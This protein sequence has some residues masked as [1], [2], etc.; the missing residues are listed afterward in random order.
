[1][2]GSVLSYNEKLSLGMYHEYYPGILGFSGIKISLPFVSSFYLGYAIQV[3]V[4]K[5]F[6]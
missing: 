1:M 6:V 2:Y 4:T 5:E 3:N